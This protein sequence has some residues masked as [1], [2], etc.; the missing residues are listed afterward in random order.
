MANILKNA[1]SH[2]I[3]A[4]LVGLKGESP[5]ELIE[6]CGRT[7]YQSRDRITPGSAEKFVEMLRNRGHE[8]VLEH[9]CMTVEFNNVSR[10]FTHELVR[11]RLASF[12]QESTRYVDES[13]FYVVI[14]PDKDESEKIV[15]LEL[16]DGKKIKI[17]FKEWADL[18]EQMYRGLRKAGWVPQDARQILPIGIKSQIV[19]TANFREWRHIFKLRTSPSAHWEIRYV[20][21]NLLKDVQKRIPVIFDDIT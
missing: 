11:H 5:L 8:S 3:L 14:P 19:V 6:L 9:S 18:N 16:P 17:S 4:I 12:T 1:G 13:N 20:M 7:S 10:G 15:E 21:T 2:K